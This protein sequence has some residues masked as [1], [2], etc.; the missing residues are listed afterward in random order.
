MGSA[1]EAGLMDFTQLKSQDNQKLMRENA[2]LKQEV[3][4][5]RR[6]LDTKK[7]GNN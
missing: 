5:L 4:K 6:R 2:D 1:N 3:L 7:S